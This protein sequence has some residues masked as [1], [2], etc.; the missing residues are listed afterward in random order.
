MSLH[1]EPHLRNVSGSSSRRT[2]SVALMASG[3]IAASL[4]M[5]PVGAQP[6][7]KYDASIMKYVI[8][9]QGKPFY[10]VAGSTASN[11][12]DWWDCSNAKKSTTKGD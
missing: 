1:S 7:C 5:M 2:V 12:G 11:Y 6:T 3:V 10:F 8:E 4:L 9:N